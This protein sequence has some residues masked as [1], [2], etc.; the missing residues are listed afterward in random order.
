LL[1]AA[2]LAI[3]LAPI[4][5]AFYTM[6]THW[7]PLP[8]WDPWHTPAAQ[9]ASWCKGTLTLG[10]LF[11]QHN[12][13]RPF[14]P[15]LVIVPMA[16][17]F[18]W[19]VRREMFLGFLLLCV[20]SAALYA[21]LRQTEKSP[22]CRLLAWAVMNLLVFTPRQA[23][24]LIAGTEGGS[25]LP[26]VALLCALAMNLSSRSL[27]V[28]TI[29]NAALAFVSTFTFGNGMLLWPLAF[30]IG[31]AAS[32]AGERSARGWRAAYILVAIAS[33]AAYFIGYR[34]PLLAPAPANVFTDAPG[35]LHFVARWIGSPFLTAAPTAIGAASLVIFC[36]LA[37]AA[38]TRIRAAGEWKSYY[39][40]LVLGAYVA[41]SGA[42]TA[43]ARLGFSLEMASDWRYTAFTVFFHVAVAGLGL[44]VCREIAARLPSWRGPLVACMAAHAAG[45]LSLSLFAFGKE[46]APLR[47]AT[48]TR[49]RLR[50]VV[51]RSLV[52]PAEPGL[53][54]LSPYPET[55]ATIRAL[56][57]CGVLWPILQ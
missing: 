46:R 49:E 28:K 55:A 32:A 53:K 34:H 14:F 52:D 4:A 7:V 47:E 15:R 31:T 26:T 19:D 13:H 3:A 20:G 8:Y 17:A 30:P 6:C 9:I 37:V 25:F 35:I 2:L 27:P 42:I 50:E 1:H 51:R 45:V 29:V 41:V 36:G 40:W 57:D 11:S 16:V 33:I 21:L 24:N 5:L 22:N 56:Q 44:T 39:P 48:G 12:E 23:E 54:L 18:G 43:R 38:V 10:E